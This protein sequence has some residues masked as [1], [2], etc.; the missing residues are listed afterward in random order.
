[1]AKPNPEEITALLQVV[2]NALKTLGDYPEIPV[3]G[4]IFTNETFDAMKRFFGAEARPF[5]TSG[6]NSDPS[7]EHSFV[8]DGML[9]LKGTPISDAPSGILVN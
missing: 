2:M 3:A 4:L 9:M 5:V 7:M 8:V 1:M 6:I